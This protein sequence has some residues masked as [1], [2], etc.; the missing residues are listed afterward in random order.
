MLP[1]EADSIYGFCC[2]SLTMHYKLVMN[3]NATAN[4]A[5]NKKQVVF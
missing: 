5:N 3:D 1:A 4:T 2:G